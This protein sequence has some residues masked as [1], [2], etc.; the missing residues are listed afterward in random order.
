MCTSKWMLLI[1]SIAHRT[2]IGYADCIA[3][4]KF[5]FKGFV[6]SITDF[7]ISFNQCICCKTCKAIIRIRCSDKRDFS[8]CWTGRFLIIKSL[9]YIE[10]VLKHKFTPFPIRQFKHF[11]RFLLS[12]QFFLLRRGNL[13]RA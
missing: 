10:Y 4:E 7:G 9:F 12:Y 5:S 8:T 13:F 6:G 11:H 3:F 1:I 2:I